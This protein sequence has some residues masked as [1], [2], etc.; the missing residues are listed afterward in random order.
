MIRVR[1]APSPTGNLHIGGSR[2]ALF[3]WLYAKAKNGQFIL[4][5]EDTDKE[6][7]KKEYLDEIL[8]SL[9]WL[10]MDW[11]EIYFQ[12]QR[13]NI[14]NEYAQRL[15]KEKKAYYASNAEPEDKDTRAM[16]AQKPKIELAEDFEQKAE[17]RLDDL[18]GDK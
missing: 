14:Y 12:S 11:D 15:L 13:Q 18:F 8:E 4:R 5:I 10:G 6:R 2:T 16:P 1:F 3:N 7:S 9:K 17:E